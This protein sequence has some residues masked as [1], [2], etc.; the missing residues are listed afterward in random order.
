MNLV[1]K[2]E[3]ARDQRPLREKEFAR[4]RSED[5]EVVT[6]FH[7]VPEGHLVRFVDRA[8]FLIELDD[9]LVTWRPVPGTS[10]QAVRDLYLNQVLPVIRGQLGELIL[11]ASAVAID[12]EVA[13]FVAGTGRGKSTLAAA[14]ARA[15]MPFL[16][17]D[18]LALTRQGAGYVAS[19]NRPSFRLWQDS[20]I[21]IGARRE[22][23]DDDEEEKSRV[24]AGAA[25]PFQSAP[26]PLRALYFLGPGDSD[27]PVIE[28]LPRHRAVAE[29]MNHA[30]LLDV[31]DR[32]C[33]QR[34][35]ETLA[36]LAEAVPSFVLDYPRDY[37]LLADVVEAVV[38]RQV[39]GEPI[40]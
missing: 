36:D 1:I 31:G 37:A 3:P 30:F 11:H 4:W 28:P 29:L 23:A 20:Q 5:G 39:D 21:A 2:E 13:A 16:S 14:F 27:A 35:F 22:P 25:L 7:R 40:Q 38:R 33:L 6:T 34:H 19:P 9:G 12:G 26:L 18:G 17:D 15:A 8:D 10:P 24:E 32:D